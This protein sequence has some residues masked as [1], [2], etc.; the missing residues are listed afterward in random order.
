[1]GRLKDKSTLLKRGKN[2]W[3]VRPS[4]KASTLGKAN[5]DRRENLLQKGGNPRGALLEYQEVPL[6]YKKRGKWGLVTAEKNKRVSRDEKE[7]KKNGP[8]LGGTGGGG[9]G[10]SSADLF[11]NPLLAKS[12]RGGGKKPRKEKKPLKWG[13]TTKESQEERG[14]KTTAL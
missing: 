9:G 11:R 13:P 12:D 7:K 3:Q 4:E 1:V 14:I 8:D 5:E 10:R 2:N 6:G